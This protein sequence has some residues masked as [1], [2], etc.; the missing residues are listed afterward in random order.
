MKHRFTS[1]LSS[2]PGPRRET[3]HKLQML[4]RCYSPSNVET[5][6]TEVISLQN[7]K[8]DLD[9]TLRKLDQE[10]EQLNH[11]TAAR[12]QMEMLNKDKV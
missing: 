1:F 12:T 5:L 10:M 9:R 6:K 2:I 8:A 7:E 11:H 3:I 4:A